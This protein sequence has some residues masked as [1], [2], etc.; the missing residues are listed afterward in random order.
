MSTNLLDELTKCAKISATKVWIAYTEQLFSISIP[1]DLPVFGLNVSNPQLIAVDARFS[2]W[3]APSRAP[4]K[5]A[6]AAQPA[7]L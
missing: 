1:S 7:E 3:A 6:P 4:Q 2:I 5:S